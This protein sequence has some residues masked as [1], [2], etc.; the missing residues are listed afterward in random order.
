MIKK[1]NANKIMLWITVIQFLITTCFYLLSI[2][3]LRNNGQVLSDPFMDSQTNC[4]SCQNAICQLQIVIIHSQ[5][6]PCEDEIQLQ[7]V[8]VTETKQDQFFSDSSK[9]F[10]GNLHDVCLMHTMICREQFNKQ[11]RQTIAL[12]TSD[13][14]VALLTI[15][16]SVK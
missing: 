3:K 1:I 14:I 6:C 15:R 12:R 8:L 2:Q 16:F 5:D 10:Y 13:R 4:T 11:K 9:H 7:A